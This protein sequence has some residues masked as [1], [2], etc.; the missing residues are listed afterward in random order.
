MVRE[1]FD[2]R[3]L[4]WPANKLQKYCHQTLYFR[5]ALTAMNFHLQCARVESGQKNT[6]NKRTLYLW[7]ESELFNAFSHFGL[8]VFLL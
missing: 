5:W 4:C 3:L 1:S 7:R 6:N 2:Q 8:A